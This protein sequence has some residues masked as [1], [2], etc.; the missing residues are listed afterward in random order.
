[1]VARSTRAVVV[2]ALLSGAAIL[3]GTALAAPTD[4]VPP[5]AAAAPEEEPQEI[6]VRG[7]RPIAES[8]AAAL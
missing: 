8:E 7:S 1:M 5:V 6:V 4:D 2:R 3:P